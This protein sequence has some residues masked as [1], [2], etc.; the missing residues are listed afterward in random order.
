MDFK[1][2]ANENALTQLKFKLGITG[3]IQNVFQ[4]VY[5]KRQKIKIIFME[6]S[7]ERCPPPVENN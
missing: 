2:A 1:M 4:G 7:M 3:I 6:F 5:T